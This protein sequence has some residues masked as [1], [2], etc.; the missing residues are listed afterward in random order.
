MLAGA[1]AQKLEQLGLVPVFVGGFGD[2]KDVAMWAVHVEAE[3]DATHQGDS[4]LYPARVQVRAKA[5][6]YIDV[7]KAA[8]QAYD[9]VLG[10][11]RTQV[12]FT[13]PRPPNT[14]TTYEVR[15]IRAMQ[16]PTWFATPEPGEEASVNFALYAREV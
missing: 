9:A 5:G 8:Q 4:E 6:N 3:A 12:T 14:Q 11:N 16:R 13:D 7:L 10:L 1:I 15:G 2:F